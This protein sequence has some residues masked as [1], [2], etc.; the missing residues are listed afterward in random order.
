MGTIMMLGYRKVVC[1]KTRHPVEPLSCYEAI[2]KRNA[3]AFSHN[4]IV[5]FRIR[6]RRHEIISA[7][8]RSGRL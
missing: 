7:A 4:A 8:Q 1:V 2:F 3:N 5:D 6:C